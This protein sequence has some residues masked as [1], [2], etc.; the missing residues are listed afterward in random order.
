M[1]QTQLLMSQPYLAIKPDIPCTSTGTSSFEAIAMLP[2]NLILKVGSYLPPFDRLQM[3]LVS[4]RFAKL[5]TDWS[6]ITLV[7]VCALHEKPTS[8]SPNCVPFGLSAKPQP[9]LEL[10]LTDQLG[11][12][13]RLRTLQGHRNPN[14]IL[15][16][17]LLRFVQLK[18]LTIHDSALASELASCVARLVTIQTLRLWNCS[19]YF[20]P[21]KKTKQQKIVH[22]LMGLPNLESL[23]ILDSMKDSADGTT[24]RA[25]FD[26]SFAT[27]IRAPLRVLQLTGVHL[28]LAT[29]ETLSL[30]IG[31]TCTRL[32][33][34]C[35]F[36]KENQRIDYIKCLHRFSKVSDI[37]LPPSI[38]HLR[39]LPTADGCVERLLQVLP[40][41][42]LGFRHYNSSILFRY[43]ETQLPMKIRVLR[44]YHHASRI[45]NFASLG[46][47]NSSAEKKSSVVSS[48]SMLS[49]S[50]SSMAAALSDAQSS[51]SDGSTDPIVALGLA[52][53][54]LTI[55]AL[56]VSL[57]LPPKPKLKQRIHC[58]VTVFYLCGIEGMQEVFGRMALPIRSPHVYHKN[59]KGNSSHGIH[60][61]DIV[62]LVPLDRLAISDTEESDNEFWN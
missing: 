29:L 19:R 57:R 18:Q 56:G 3:Q 60:H 48:T 16:W 9:R 5:F 45:P 52:T 34:G 20:L 12:T 58:G 10:R 6:D 55:F 59:L 54:Q 13:S 17:M 11:R 41:K 44:I 8:S 7:E 15:K 38:F 31:S 46:Q 36:C 33:F 37:D 47:S 53:R 62:K 51:S 25:V 42:A 39:D 50:G 61:G 27:Q 1:L 28:P 22:A 26:K 2:D 32:S 14:K 21:E 43:I 4:R 35:T 24:C 49:T 30:N 23:L 40:L